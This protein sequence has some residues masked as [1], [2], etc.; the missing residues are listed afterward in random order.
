MWDGFHI[1]IFFLLQ[2]HARG[3][4]ARLKFIESEASVQPRAARGYHHWR[5][6]L[7]LPGGVCAACPLI[8]HSSALLGELADLWK[9]WKRSHHQNLLK[10]NGN[11]LRGINGLMRK[12]LLLPWCTTR[13]NN[14]L[15]QFYSALFL[16][17]LCFQILRDRNRKYEVPGPSR[18]P[19]IIELLWFA[20]MV[21]D[22][23][24][25]SQRTKLGNFLIQ[26]PS[27]LLITL[28][29]TMKSS[30]YASKVSVSRVNIGQSP[31]I[32]VL[33]I[34]PFWSHCRRS[35]GWNIWMH[36]LRSS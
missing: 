24:R 10:L 23:R 18:R 27:R 28:E 30:R 34:L 21:R 7:R 4:A 9:K 1:E 14:V 26:K 11:I 22:V 25:R 35:H 19:L 12:W 16:P 13:R 20:L 32:R 31:R 17:C 29:Q 33:S 36:E 15:F 3:T 6:R 5:R 8:L 2:V